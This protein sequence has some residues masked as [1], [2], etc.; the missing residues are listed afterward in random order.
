[1]EP[2]SHNK[3]LLSRSN[4]MKYLVDMKLKKYTSHND[5]KHKARVERIFFLKQLHI[6]A[7]AVA[8]AMF[9]GRNVT[10]ERD[11]TLSS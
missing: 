10:L 3:S 2:F 4:S 7:V 9:R 5:R 11:P 8:P 1:M 6:I